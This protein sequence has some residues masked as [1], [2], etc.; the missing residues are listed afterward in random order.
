MNQGDAHKIEQS[1]IPTARRDK[2][3]WDCQA[4][5][6]ETNPKQKCDCG[7]CPIWKLQNEPNFHLFCQKTR[8]S[9]KT[10]PIQTQN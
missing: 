5:K 3:I 10:N 9:Q 7:S 2:P 6:N 1:E 4:M 8:F